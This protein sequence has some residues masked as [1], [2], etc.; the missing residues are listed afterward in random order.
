[1]I[2][3]LD[4]SALVPLLVDEPTSADCGELWDGADSVTTTRLAYI[5]AVAAL[6]QAERM[7]RITASEVRGGRSVL[8]DLWSVVDVIELGEELMTYA[9]GLAVAHGLRGY[10][11]AHCAAAIAAN[12]AELVAASGD[13]RLLT[14]WR[15]EGVAVRDTHA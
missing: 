5:E 10:D 6:A 9:A 8:D 12:D 7:G 11:A 3:Y 4:T 1:M 13:T 14:A 15:A 2:L